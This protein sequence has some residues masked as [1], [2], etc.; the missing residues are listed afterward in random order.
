MISPMSRIF[1]L[2]TCA[3]WQVQR[4]AY[5]LKLSPRSPQRLFLPNGNI[6]LH[7]ICNGKR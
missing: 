1:G 7:Y 6:H 3:T 5:V 2:H 4:N